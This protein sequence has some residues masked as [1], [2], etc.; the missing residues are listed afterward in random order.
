MLLGQD[1]TDELEAQLIAAKQSIQRRSLAQ[2]QSKR[3]D[4]R[5][6]ADRSSLFERLANP[7][8]KYP[9]ATPARE[10]DAA[11]AEAILQ[12]IASGNKHVPTAQRGS[13]VRKFIKKK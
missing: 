10:P 6:S 11:R 9:G 7:R 1:P 12:Q 13:N 4:K 3:D 5:E 8:I 2:T